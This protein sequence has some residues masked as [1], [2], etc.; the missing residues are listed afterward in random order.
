MNILLITSVYKNEVVGPARFARLLESSSLIDVD[1]LTANVEETDTL[2]SVNINYSWWQQKL[3]IYFSIAPFGKRINELKSDYDVLLFNSSVL[4]DP[5]IMTS[6]YFVMVN[7]EKLASLKFRFNFD[8]FRRRLHQKI[9]KRAVLHAEKVIVN[10][11]YLKN[12][13]ALRYNLRSDKICVLYKGISFENKKTDF[14][15][16]LTPQKNVVEILF[17]KNDYLLGGLTDLVEALGLLKGF[18][19]KLT[20]VG[21]S[22]SVEKHLIKYP[23]VTY[24]ILGFQSNDNVI[25]SMYANDILCIPS[26]FEP[27]GVAVMEGLAVGIPTITTGAGGLPEVTSHGE[28]VWECEPNNPQS[29]SRQ[30]EDCITNSEARK[31]KSQKGKRYIQKKFGFNNVISNLKEILEN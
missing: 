2:K 12:R 17:V 15:D 20:I 30:L 14:Q 26:R 3:K 11:N 9:E 21:T 27:L 22:R 7:D 16:N 31:E 19:F 13:I 1:I 28:Y 25:A 24:E 4:A 18:A 8:Y 5:R 23:N 10:S 29:I 6:P